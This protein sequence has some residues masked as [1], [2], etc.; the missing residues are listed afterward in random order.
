MGSNSFA[1]RKQI[2]ALLV[3]PRKMRNIPVEYD[4][5]EFHSKKEGA[6]YL[7][8]KTLERV[9]EIEG[10]E[11]QKRFKLV[12][13]GKLGGY[14]ELGT[15]VSDFYYREAKGS[16]E[17]VVEDVKGRKSGGPYE[18]FKLKKRLML[19]LYGVEVREI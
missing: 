5:I 12:M 7:Q 15:Y 4:G 1:V 17:W 2:P 8:L 6:R 18:M 16:R 3:P 11:T 19:A 13:E 14:V 10:L 9:G